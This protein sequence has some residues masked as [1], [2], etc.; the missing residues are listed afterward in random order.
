[1]SFVEKRK[2]KRFPINQEGFFKGHQTAQEN[3]IIR[4]LSLGGVFIETPSL[5]PVGSSLTV[6]CKVAE[7]IGE[8]CL[9]GVVVRVNTNESIEP[10]G[11][12]AQFSSLTFSQLAAF[13][14]LISWWKDHNP[15]RDIYP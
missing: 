4:N 9:S 12:G 10:R 2:H 13:K 1:M 5:L 8:L 14:K 7:E 3:C 6:S 11:M 15:T